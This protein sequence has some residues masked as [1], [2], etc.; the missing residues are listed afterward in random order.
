MKEKIF[1]F[2]LLTL[3]FVFL[4]TVIINTYAKYTTSRETR[5]QARVAQWNIKLNK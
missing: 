5:A 1:K 2:T 3:I 4:F